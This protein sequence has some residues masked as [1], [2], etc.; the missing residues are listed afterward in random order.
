[1][2]KRLKLI[3]LNQVD[4]NLLK[5]LRVKVLIVKRINGLLEEEVYLKKFNN[6]TGRKKVIQIQ[7][8]EK[9]KIKTNHLSK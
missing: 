1:M 2:N 7:K 9:L 4:L 8:L 6:N 5:S 3:T